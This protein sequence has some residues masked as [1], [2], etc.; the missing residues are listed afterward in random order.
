MENLMTFL[1][2]F[3]AYFIVLVIIVAVM[4]IASCIGINL[5]KSKNEKEALNNAEGSETEN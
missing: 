3:Q 4:L 5:R 1:N 2:Y